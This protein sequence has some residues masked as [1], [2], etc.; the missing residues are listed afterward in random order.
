MNL[1][2]I[3]QFLAVYPGK[4]YL[5]VKLQ[6]IQQCK[7]TINK[8]RFHVPSFIIRK[9]EYFMIFLYSLI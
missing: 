9:N 7:S 6:L 4:L 2:N 1:E 5:K 8:T 3:L